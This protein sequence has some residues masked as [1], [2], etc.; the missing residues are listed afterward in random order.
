MNL[1]D[2]TEEDFADGIA[3][4]IDAILT[5]KD[6]VERGDW[7]FLYRVVFGYTVKWFHQQWVNFQLK[8]RFTVIAGPRGFGKTV[9]CTKGFALI[10]SVESREHRILIVGKTL[11]QARKVQ[12]EIRLQLQ[13]NE[14]MKVFG[15]FFDDSAS[16]D[17]G[18]ELIFAGRKNLHSEP[19]I[20]CVG[21]GSAKVGGHYDIILCEDLVDNANSSGRNAELLRGWVLEELIGMLMPD[22][23]MH[24]IQS[25][26]GMADLWVDLEKTGI[27]EMQSTPALVDDNGRPSLDGHSIWEEMISTEELL[28][29]R[30]MMG[31]PYFMAQYQQ[32]VSS[33]GR[34]GQIRFRE[35]AVEVV[36]LSRLDPRSMSLSCGVDLGASLGKGGAQTVFSISGHPSD[37]ASPKKD[38][39]LDI[40]AGQWELEEIDEIFNLVEKKWGAI[41][42]RVESNAIQLLIANDQASKHDVEPV[43]TSIPRSKRREN[44]ALKFNSGRV[45]YVEGL[46]EEMR[47]FWEWP[48][49][50]REDII[51]SVDL[52]LGGLEDDQG[53]GGFDSLTAEG[54]F[55]GTGPQ[56]R[57]KLLEL[58][59]ERKQLGMRERKQPAGRRGMSSG[60]RFAALSDLSPSGNALRSY[61]E[62]V[63]V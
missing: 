2:F 60:R 14:L 1:N 26:Y 12:R 16:V 59:E 4:D 55:R 32:N 45:G 5:V 8:N 51:D 15:P 48:D 43:N 31:D 35:E 17:T 40:M 58:L 44:L 13:R 62:E 61:K 56:S 53:E 10:K 41:P 22:G 23:E 34:L 29:R 21:I 27:F 46:E 30:E 25:R 54:E 3:E 42:F 63:G 37:D 18:T 49:W 24:F 7:P 6:A 19:N 36:P 52:S 20:S 28:K 33:L 47:E 38:W 11:P 57:S 9:V 50:Y 39:I